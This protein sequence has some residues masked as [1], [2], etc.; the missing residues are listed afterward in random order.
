MS[1]APGIPFSLV[2]TMTGGIFTKAAALAVCLAAVDAA[3]ETSLITRAGDWQ[4]FGGTTSGGRPVCGVS[5][6]ASDHY[7]GLKF[8]S[9]DSTFT[10]QM[11]A[12]SWRLE[13]GAQQKLQMILDSNRPWNVTGTG[14][15]FNDGD[16]GLE[17]TINR[18]E[19]DQ[20]AVEFR[21]SSTLRVQF[22]SDAAE[23]SLSLAGS[24]AVTGA[25]LQCIEGLTR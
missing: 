18:A 3:A 19:L 8:F 16:A 1:G 21:G 12:K 10:V 6:S 25:F 22:S 11:G 2:H 15:H 20:F 7:F 5:Q 4:A 14:M 13:N 9:G 23:W 17:F 24:N